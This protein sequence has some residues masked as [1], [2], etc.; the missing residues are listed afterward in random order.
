M[1]SHAA[2]LADLLP[3]A[4]GAGTA[5]LL[6]NSMLPN[7]TFASSIHAGTVLL[8]EHIASEML[9][10]EAKI[11]CNR[12]CVANVQIAIWLRRESRQDLRD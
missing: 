8:D 6:I 11:D 4:C 10:S 7:L 5:E 2:S 12:L 9:L 1:C 3:G